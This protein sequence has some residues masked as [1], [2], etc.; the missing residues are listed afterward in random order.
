MKMKKLSPLDIIPYRYERRDVYV[1]TYLPTGKKYVGKSRNVKERFDRHYY[2]L[3]GRRHSVV[4][5]QRDYDKY[6]GGREAFKVEIIDCQLP[7]LD[8]RND[9]EHTAMI[10]LK[11]YDEHYG[12]NTHDQ[13]VQ[14]M[15]EKCGLQVVL[16]GWQKRKAMA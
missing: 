8:D 15:R 14:W 16:F 1:I 10:R 11:T 4:E 5:F 2:A 9:P 6:G 7:F 3:R 12:Y 13:L